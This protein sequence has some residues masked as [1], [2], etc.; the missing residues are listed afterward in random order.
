MRVATVLIVFLVLLL[1]DLLTQDLLDVL[2]L[3]VSHVIPPT[4][5]F[6]SRMLPQSHYL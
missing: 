5:C 4:K 2:A 3:L 6:R 1:V